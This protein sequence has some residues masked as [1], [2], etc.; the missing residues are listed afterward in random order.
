MREYNKTINTSWDIS[1]IRLMNKSEYL[2]LLQ[3]DNE[4][5]RMTYKY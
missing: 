4:Q 2:V 3:F 1:E 5:Y